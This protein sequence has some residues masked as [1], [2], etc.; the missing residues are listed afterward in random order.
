MLPLG[1]ISTGNVLSNRKTENMS[2]G[3]DT[4][5]EIA[6]SAVE[7]LLDFHPARDE[8]GRRLCDISSS[9][10][11][12]YGSITTAAHRKCLEFN[13]LT[14]TACFLRSGQPHDTRVTWLPTALHVEDGFSGADSNVVGL[15]I[16]EEPLL[17]LIKAADESDGLY[18]GLK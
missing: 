7:D 13:P 2:A 3:V 18:F 10:M 12:Q 17:P 15:R 1:L 14:L 5:A 6:P 11:M 8:R 16:L 4:R 9:P